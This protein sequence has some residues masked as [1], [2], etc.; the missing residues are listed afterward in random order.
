MIVGQ[1]M[2]TVYGRLP[3]QPF[4][5][6]ARIVKLKLPSVVGVPESVPP[7]ERSNPAGRLPFETM[8]L[9]GLRPPLAVMFL[10]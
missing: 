5:S 10:W 2:V 9:Y 8:K 1:A 3:V 6:V 7:L 4:L